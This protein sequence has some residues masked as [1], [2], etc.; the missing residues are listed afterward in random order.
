MNTPEMGGIHI[1]RLNNDGA[2]DG[3]GAWCDYSAVGV[4]Y[5][6]HT[7][8]AFT[9]LSL[10]SVLIGLGLMMIGLTLLFKVFMPQWAVFGKT[11][12]NVKY[13]AVSQSYHGNV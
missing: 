11:E 10:E 5:H 4:L 2:P 9:G 3:S 8:R 7:V 12:G 6:A 1:K 13:E